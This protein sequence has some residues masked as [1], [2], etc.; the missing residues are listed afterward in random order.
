MPSPDASHMTYGPYAGPRALA[1]GSV[2][3]S[4]DVPLIRTPY[5]PRQWRARPSKGRSFGSSEQVTTS[6]DGLGDLESLPAITAFLHPDADSGHEPTSLDDW[7]FIDAGAQTSELSG[8]LRAPDRSFLGADE[9]ASPQ[10]LPMWNDDDLMDIMPAPAATPSDE[11]SLAASLMEF[12]EPK[13]EYGDDAAASAEREEQQAANGE[14]AA[15]T[16]ETLAQRVRSGE[17]VVPG[18]VPEL[19]D[20]AVLAAALGALLGIRS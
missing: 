1:L 8:D 17:I 16:L 11:R 14:H 6:V 7:P 15:R 18:Y 2:Q 5:I 20:A 3:A 19:G 9:G 13:T 12:R 4:T 10:P